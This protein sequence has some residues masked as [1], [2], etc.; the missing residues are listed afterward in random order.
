MHKKTSI[1]VIIIGLLLG[2]FLLFFL[3][4]RFHVTQSNTRERLTVAVVTNSGENKKVMIFNKKVGTA[5]GKRINKKVVFKT[6]T[7]ATAMQNKQ[8]YA[9]I[10][11]LYKK[12]LNKQERKH[13]S[14]YLYIPN[15][16]VSL[17]SKGLSN[18]TATTA[19]I[20][21]VK[22][23]DYPQSLILSDIK[24]H[25]ERESS[26]ADA[27]DS[28]MTKRTRAAIISTI[29]YTTL[30]SKNIAYLENLKTNQTTPSISAQTYY[31][32]LNKDSSVKKAF[33]A[34]QESQALAKLS[35]NILGQDY[36][37]Q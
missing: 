35:F 26:A 25:F 30:T 4:L 13:A 16:L 18:L 1:S 20:A 21:L 5:L 28:V 29:D 10:I 34:F 19:K 3:V 14:A 23:L 8:K 27:I 6:V 22:N 17:K 36:T 31:L 12:A 37:K 9:A 7:A 11:G 33:T 32:Y 24:L 2:L 15:E